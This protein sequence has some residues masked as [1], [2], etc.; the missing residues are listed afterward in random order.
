MRK[1]RRREGNTEHQEL[2]IAHLRQKLESKTD[3]AIIITYQEQ[4]FWLLALRGVSHS[5]ASV[6]M[7]RERR[8]LG[9]SGGPIAVE[10][11]CIEI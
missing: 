2:Q 10:A 6:L 1:A 4:D 5:Q 9:C 3:E 8:A 7:L 11:K